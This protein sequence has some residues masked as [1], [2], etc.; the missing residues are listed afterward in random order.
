MQTSD[1]LAQSCHRVAVSTA[2]SGSASAAAEA[3]ESAAAKG[4]VLSQGE[5][6]LVEATFAEK[7][8]WMHVFY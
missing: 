6:R 7:Y 2:V 3:I 8:W 1:C 4:G 5:G